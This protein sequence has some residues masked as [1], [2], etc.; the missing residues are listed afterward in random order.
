[1]SSFDRAPASCN[2]CYAATLF[3]G[4]RKSKVPADLPSKQVG[5][6]GVSREGFHD[7]G[8]G[9]TPQRMRTTFALEVAA[10]PPNVPQQRG[11]LHLIE[12]VVRSAS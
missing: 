9:I 12:T 10:V 7:P 8:L 1:M 4:V 5:D 6:L 2:A 3:K 11:A